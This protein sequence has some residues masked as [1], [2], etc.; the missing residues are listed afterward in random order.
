M[1]ETALCAFVML[2]WWY[3]GGTFLMFFNGAAHSETNMLVRQAKK[4]GNS[5]LKLRVF[6]VFHCIGY[7]IWFAGWFVIPVFFKI[8]IK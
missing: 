2:L 7:I 3:C 1:F 6:Q 8:Y 4:E 5:T